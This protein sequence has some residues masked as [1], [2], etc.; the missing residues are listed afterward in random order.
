MRKL[1]VDASEDPVTSDILFTLQLRTTNEPLLPNLETFEC[2][3]TIDGAFIHFIPTF[4][5]RETT[6]IDIGFDEDSPTVMFTSIITKLP[7]LCPNLGRITLNDLPR[8]PVII[9]AASEMLLACNRDTL[10]GSA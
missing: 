6:D 3:G 2:E 8:D 10:N 9:E 4:L 5:S 7:T 1:A